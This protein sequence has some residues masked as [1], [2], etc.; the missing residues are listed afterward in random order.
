MTIENPDTVDGMGFDPESGRL[1][2][3]VYDHLDW[4][5]EQ[6]HL[7]LIAAKITNYMTFLLSGQAREAH[8]ERP[9]YAFESPS[10]SFSF[11]VP[12]TPTALEALGLIAGQM[13]TA[14][15]SLDYETG[16]GAEAVAFA[17]G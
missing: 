7:Q 10:I 5:D 4:A 16:E 3:R 12:P 2:L 13:R 8:P 17:F 15:V 14:G 6:A 9:D 1:I 11:R